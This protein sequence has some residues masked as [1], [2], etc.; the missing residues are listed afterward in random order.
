MTELLELALK[1]HGGL[2]RWQGFRSVEATFFVGGE[3]LQRKVA[4]K[5][6]TQPPE[7]E[8]EPKKSEPVQM[9]VSTSDQVGSQTP[10]VDQVSS[11]ATRQIA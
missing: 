3:L 11:R 7:S 8:P 10:L 5:F 6:Q 4:G 9:T 2:N 1:A